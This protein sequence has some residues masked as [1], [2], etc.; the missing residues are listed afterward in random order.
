MV[1]N[2]SFPNPGTTLMKYWPLLIVI[3]MVIGAAYVGQRDIAANAEDIL[4]NVTDIGQLENRVIVE[5][6]STQ[7]A[8][9]ALRLKQEAAI[10]AQQATAT[11]QDDKLDL[12]LRSLQ[13]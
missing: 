11:R 9:Q 13:K 12:I 5:G 3:G 2:S 8:L 6:T 10:K 1:S 7:L 4:T